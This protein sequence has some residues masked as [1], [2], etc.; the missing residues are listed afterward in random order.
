MKWYVRKECLSELENLPKGDTRTYTKTLLRMLE[1][2]NA[3]T[4]HGYEH[5]LALKTLHAFERL[6]QQEVFVE[7]EV[8]EG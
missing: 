6:L 2:E 4:L 1:A 8:G 7:I 5:T 3:F